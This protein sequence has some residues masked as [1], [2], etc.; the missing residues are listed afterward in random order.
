[1]TKFDR[2]PTF[3]SATPSRVK[4]SPSAQK[5][6]LLTPAHLALEAW[7]TLSSLGF[8]HLVIRASATSQTPIRHKK[9]NRRHS[10]TQT[11]HKP[12]THSNP[13]KTQ[14]KTQKTQKKNFLR[15]VKKGSPSPS[16]PGSSRAL[17]IQ[18]L[19]S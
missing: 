17:S 9:H 15:A 2:Q 6:R 4:F 3:V 10:Q 11:G 14:I 5:S 16:P 1:M 7:D 13:R 12:Q 8:G 18:V 19:S